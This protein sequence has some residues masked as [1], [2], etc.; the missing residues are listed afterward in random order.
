MALGHCQRQNP[1][2]MWLMQYI[3]FFCFQPVLLHCVKLEGSC[4]Y[5][6]APQ[7]ENA[8]YTWIIKV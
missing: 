4:I 3:F 7:V 6:G 5:F 8:V 2:H 1:R